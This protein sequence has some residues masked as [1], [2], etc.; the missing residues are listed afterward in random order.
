MDV[1]ETPQAL[2]RETLSP[3]EA[4]YDVAQ[5]PGLKDHLSAGWQVAGFKGILRGGVAFAA[6]MLPMLPENILPE[7][8]ANSPDAADLFE[9]VKQLAN[10]D[11]IAPVGIVLALVLGGYLGHEYGKDK[12]FGPAVGTIGG[13]ALTGAALSLVAENFPKLAHNVMASMQ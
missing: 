3:V 6:G 9:T 2:E 4:A 1:M 8:V 10:K 12:K 13:A 11:A 7:S 5:I